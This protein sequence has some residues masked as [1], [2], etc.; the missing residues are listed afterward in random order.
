[1]GWRQTVQKNRPLVVA[2][3][4]VVIAGCFFWITSQGDKRGAVPGNVYFYDLKTRQLFSVNRNK[5]PPMI[6]PSGGESVKAVTYSCGECSQGTPEVA[7]LTSYTEQALSAINEL[8]TA[9]QSN[10]DMSL[11]RKIQEG[12]LVALPPDA[13][14]S[15]PN[16]VPIDSP[17]A[18]AIMN[19]LRDACG[20]GSATEC[21]PE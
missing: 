9:T 21:F 4:V 2:V 20:N 16:W 13:E 8:A 11:P 1:M 19:R 5:Q 15:A 10:A 18:S 6:A 3:T 14:G 17:T 12:T 7:Y